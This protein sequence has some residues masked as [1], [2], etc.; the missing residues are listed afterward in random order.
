MRCQHFQLVL[1]N[2]EAITLKPGNFVV[3]SIYLGIMLCALQDSVILLDAVHP[4]P[5]AGLCE[6]NGVSPSSSKGINEDT[7][8]SGSRL[9]NVVGDFAS[10]C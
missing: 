8:S 4:F 1:Q 3:D 9:G 5:S 2:T 10:S 7:T 6:G